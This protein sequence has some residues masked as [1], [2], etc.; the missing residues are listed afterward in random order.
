MLVL[1][2]VSNREPSPCPMK[3]T[4]IFQRFS[5]DSDRIA[6]HRAVPVRGIHIR[7]F[8]GEGFWIN[9]ATVWTR[10]CGHL[11]A[12]LGE[13]KCWRPLGSR[14]ASGL[15][16]VKKIAPQIPRSWLNMTHYILDPWTGEQ[17]SCRRETPWCFL[18]SG[19]AYQITTH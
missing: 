6:D 16:R 2:S 3:T 10:R 11:L 7:D 4:V 17:Q 9:G 15:G 5:V 1:D 18:L 19:L 14:S 13:Y 12:Y 8:V